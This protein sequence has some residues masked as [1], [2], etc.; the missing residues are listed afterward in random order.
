V[1]LVHRVVLQTSDLRP[2][3]ALHANSSGSRSRLS[4]GT[5]SGK[6]GPGLLRSAIDADATDGSSG[7]QVPAS[8]VMATC[9]SGAASSVPYRSCG[10]GTGTLTSS[11]SP[12]TSQSAELQELRAETDSEKRS[13]SQ[14]RKPHSEPKDN[15]QAPRREAERAGGDL[16]A[17]VV[18]AGKADQLAAAAAAAVRTPLVVGAVAAV[19]EQQALRTIHPE[20]PVALQSSSSSCVLPPLPPLPPT[21]VA[22]R[23]PDP[24]SLMAIQRQVLLGSCGVGWV[25]E[26]PCTVVQDNGLMLLEITTAAMAVCDYVLFVCGLICT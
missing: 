14:R 9:S 26:G 10:T 11:S 23:A 13:A 4:R 24:Q 19:A 18:A 21:I 6:D 15:Q 25:G 1:R 12:D 20:L 17:E 16:V 22:T 7:P 5:G 8:S 3:A 2:G